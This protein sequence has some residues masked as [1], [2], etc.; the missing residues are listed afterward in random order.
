MLKKDD[1]ILTEQL[2]VEHMENLTKALYIFTRHGY[3]TD[4]EILWAI[5]LRKKYEAILQPY[6]NEQ[7]ELEYGKDKPIVNTVPDKQWV[8]DTIA[9]THEVVKRMPA[10]PEID[11]TLSD[12]DDP[13]DALD[14]ELEALLK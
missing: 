3:P 7:Y 4:D 5:L 8:A 14:A 6:W 13:N 11:A 1:V 9:T 2:T 12:D 10:T